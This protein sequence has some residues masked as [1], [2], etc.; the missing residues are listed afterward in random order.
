MKLST[1]EVK[2]RVDNLLSEERCEFSGLVDTEHCKPFLNK[3]A[4]MM[5]DLGKAYCDLQAHYD[6]LWSKE[7]EALKLKIAEGEERE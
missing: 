5:H 6:T 4:E 3:M 2:L 1:E 7:Q